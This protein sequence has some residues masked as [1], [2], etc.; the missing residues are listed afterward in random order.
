MLYSRLFQHYLSNDLS[1]VILAIYG[2]MNIV[3][4]IFM[5]IASGEAFMDSCDGVGL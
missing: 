4:N 2:I 3:I 5:D 1:L